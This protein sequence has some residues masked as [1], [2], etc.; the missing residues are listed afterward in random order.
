MEETMDEKQLRDAIAAHP[1]MQ[2]LGVLA[3]ALERVL[4][5]KSVAALTE[6]DAAEANERRREGK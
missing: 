1:T 5:R 2:R 4:K 3:D 6:S